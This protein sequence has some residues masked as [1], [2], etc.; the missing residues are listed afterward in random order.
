MLCKAG[1][2]E[3]DAVPETYQPL[4]RWDFYRCL[5]FHGAKVAFFPWKEECFGSKVEFN[6]R[7]SI[8][9]Q[10]STQKTPSSKP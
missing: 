9:K 1:T 6:R 5:Q 7:K 2:N 8:K 4:G 10:A 3:C